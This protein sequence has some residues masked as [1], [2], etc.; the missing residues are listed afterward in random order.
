MMA[1]P[2]TALITLACA[3]LGK[4]FWEVVWLSYPMIAWLL[5]KKAGSS[6]TNGNLPT[7]QIESQ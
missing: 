5:R 2:T 7:G 4:T 3:P 1:E 6:S